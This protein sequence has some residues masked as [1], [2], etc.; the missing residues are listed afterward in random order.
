MPHRVFNI[1]EVAQ[2][3]HL[4]PEDVERLVKRGEVP[5]ERQGERL[6][7]RRQEIDAWASQRIMSLSDD[8]LP[9]FHT[10]S[11][12]RR[13]AISDEEALIPCL[14]SKDRIAPA[15]A[16][17]TRASVLRDMVALAN[18]TGLPTD[19]TELLDAIEEREKLCSTALPG[20]VALLHPRHHTPYLTDASFIV[21]G[22][23]VQPI[24]FGSM[25]GQPTDL[26]FLL[27]CQDDHLHLHALARLC[28]LY[29]KTRILEELRTADG[30]TE[31]YHAITAAEAQILRGICPPRP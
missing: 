16:S 29:Q 11:T 20:G 22:R 21:I 27:C 24:H 25:D 5:C 6:V 15:L 12:A 26:F 17:R 8:Q 9:G 7:F 1:R 4:A 30:A 31:M 10:K 14:L 18:A 13:R 3:L 28:T 2:Y 19:P 23:V